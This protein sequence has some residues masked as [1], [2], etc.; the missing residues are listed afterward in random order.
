MGLYKYLVDDPVHLKPI[1]HN[2]GFQ[3]M[4]YIP[5]G[6]RSVFHFRVHSLHLYSASG[7]ETIPLLAMFCWL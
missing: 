5:A 2:G 7:S 4:V 3:I 1:T 6:E